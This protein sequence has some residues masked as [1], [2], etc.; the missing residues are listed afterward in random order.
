MTPATID[1]TTCQYVRGAATRATL[2]ALLSALAALTGCDTEEVPAIEPDP[3]TVL[4][5]MPEQ[6]TR[7]TRAHFEF[8]SPTGATRFH[9]SLDG[10]T[11]FECASPLELD[12]TDGEHR[13]VVWAI[14]DSGLRDKSAVSWRWRVDATPPAAAILSGPPAYD[15][16]AAPTFTF[17]SEPDALY[18]CSVDDGPRQLCASP[19]RLDALTDGPHTFDVVAI[20]EVGN[21]QPTPTRRGWILDTTTP[22]VTFD[23]TPPALSNLTSATFRF[24]ATHGASP[25][26]LTCL[27]DG[28]F[29]TP[30]SSPLT[31]A[32][33]EGTHSLV[34]RATN[35]QGITDPTPASYTFRVD[36]TAP[37]VSFSS[38]PPAMT[39]QRRLTYYFSTFEQ[40]LTVECRA[41][42]VGDVEASFTPCDRSFSV[43]NV[44]DGT[45][46][47]TVRATDLAGNFTALTTSTTVDTVPPGLTMQER[48][49]TRSA[50]TTPTF[51]FQTS[52]A[53]ST[54]CSYDGAIW[55]A[56]SS[57]RTLSLTEGTYE[58][59]V[60]A[61]DAVGNQT[62]DRTTFTIDYSAPIVTFTASPNPSTAASSAT[63]AFSAP[64]ADLHTLE[65]SYDSATY[66]ACTSPVTISSVTLG[67]HV[68]TVRATDDL[69]NWGTRSYRFF[70]DPR[71]IAVTFENPPIGEIADPTPPLRWTATVYTTQVC[72]YDANDFT[73]SCSS[74]LATPLTDGPHTFSVKI[75]NDLGQTTTATHSFT[76]DTVAP[77][78][79]ITGGPTG[80]VTTPAVAFTFVPSDDTATTECRLFRQGQATGA[81][82]PCSSPA[83]FDLAPPSTPYPYTFE[84]RVGD[85][86]GNL[87]S[88]YRS[89]TYAP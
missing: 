58:Y 18:T 69:G 57:P 54:D 43:A 1:P 9:C 59:H 34:V 25:L 21:V 13:F 10:R 70:A 37:I 55:H 77:S 79:A 41:Q 44:P 17:E 31:F 85:S 76:V 16:T 47:F 86:A 65:C 27:W 64:A 5:K 67:Y 80:N 32:P 50:D 60:R 66:A 26:T 6:V 63:F 11:P 36:R 53:T 52:G 7:L 2:A 39:N 29:T 3:E 56:C 40:D 62:V 75:T 84:V 30:C 71:P 35:A 83:A 81:Y 14:S 22:D 88:A 45:L 42:L 20:D 72:R 15:N 12:V 78:V 73:S 74:V 48:P 51:V 38:T 68:F 61:R 24:T 8:T 4:N 33:S 28:H 19:Y 23:A 46:E 49:A 87:W 82:A 89:F